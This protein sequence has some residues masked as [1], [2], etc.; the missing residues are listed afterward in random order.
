MQLAVARMIVA[1]MHTHL[2]KQ[3]RI[4]RTEWDYV[5]AYAGFGAL[6]C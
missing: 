2:V 4:C 6:M 1:T 5:A 3:L